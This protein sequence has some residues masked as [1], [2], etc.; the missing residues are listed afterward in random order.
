MIFI[1]A[2]HAANMSLR[3]SKPNLWQP[4][5]SGNRNEVVKESG[6]NVTEGLMY[7]AEI[8]QIIQRILFSV[9][10][11][12]NFFVCTPVSRWKKSRKKIL[13][14]FFFLYAVINLIYLGKNNT[15]LW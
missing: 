13:M 15:L 10:K 9:H 3:G 12:Q 11:L 4:Q 8:W 2:A 1:T 6:S 14:K 7:R 5:V